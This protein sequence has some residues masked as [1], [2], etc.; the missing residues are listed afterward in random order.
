MDGCRVDAD[1]Q[2]TDEPVGAVSVFGALQLYV[3]TRWNSVWQTASRSKVRMRLVELVARTLE[4]K[5]DRE[6]LLAALEEQRPDRRRPEPRT[7]VE[8][9]ARYLRDYGLRPSPVE[10]GDEMASARRWTEVR[11]IPLARLSIQHVAQLR[12]HFTRAELAQSSAR[13]YWPAR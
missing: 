9:A 11:S 1:G 2:P 5:R 10:L 7:P 6:A 13:T 12:D 4:P 8:W 3:A